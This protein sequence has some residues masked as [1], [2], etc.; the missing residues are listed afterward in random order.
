M[1][2][3]L[4]DW[5]FKTPTAFIAVLSLLVALFTYRYQRNWNRRLRSQE[6]TDWY[7]RIVLPKFRYINYILNEVGC[8]E[9]TK[10]FSKIEDFDTKELK[11]NFSQAS[12]NI[13]E[14][15]EKLNKIT[16]NILNRAFLESGCNEYIY[17]THKMLIK[18]IDK[19]N[20][21]LE[22]SI[23]NKYVIDLL[24]E[25]EGKALQLNYCVYDEKMLYPILHQ[26][27]VKN[28]EHLYVFISSENIQDYDQFY[29]YT[30]WLYN[31]WKKR[32]SSERR[33]LKRSVAKKSRISKM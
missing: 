6:I 26:T 18:G 28:I 2:K 32:V 30:I 3:N 15:K 13:D 1:I 8:L 33:R 22:C 7:A 5:F 16:L 23:F 27:Y 9:T 31:L 29:I 20:G 21:C 25:L 12:S 4:L 10:K 17:K 19:K 11:D 24:N 14:Y